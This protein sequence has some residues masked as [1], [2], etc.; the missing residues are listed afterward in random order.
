MPLRRIF[1]KHHVEYHSYADDIQLYVAFIPKSSE[2]LHTAINKLECFIAEVRSWM[3][4]NKLK[5][6]DQKTEFIIF[7]SPVFSKRFPFDQCF[8]Q[9]GGE[10]IKASQKVCD[11]GSFLDNSLLM[12]SN[13][14]SI[15]GSVYD[16]MRNLAKLCRYFDLESCASVINSMIT[17]RLDC[18]N[19]LLYGVRKST[20]YQQQLA[21]NH[22]ARL[23]T[24]TK[25]R[26]RIT[27]VLQS[28][29]WLPGEWQVLVLVFSV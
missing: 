14:A 18:N 11:L 21:Q 23:L 17:S 24:G 27:P 15:S 2:D 12:G 13:V 25:Y 3:C 6:N 28:L 1:Q 4:Q 29:H 20:V 22:D 8:L 19:S 9:V 7:S 10:I 16:Q 5:F 26:E